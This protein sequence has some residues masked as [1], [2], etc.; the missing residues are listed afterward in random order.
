ME[1]EK[2]V[3]LKK[4][5]ELS[6]DDFN[7]YFKA[8]KILE[9]KGVIGRKKYNSLIDLRKRYELHNENS[10][11]NEHLKL[12]EIEEK[13]ILQYESENAILD[14]E[15]HLKEKE[16]L[17]NLRNNKTNKIQTIEGLSFNKKTLYYGFLD[18]YKFLYQKDFVLNSDTKPNL[19]III[20]Y[21]TQDPTFFDCE[22]LV[23][24]I[25]GL[26][27]KMEPSF[28]KGFIIVGRY[29]NGKS[30]IMKTFEFLINHNYQVALEKKWDNML[31]WQSKRFKIANTHDLVTEYEWISSP[32]EKETFIKKY[33]TFRYCFDDLKKEKIAS[34]Y[35]NI[36]VVQTLLEKRYDGLMYSLKIVDK[37]KILTFGT[38]NYESKKP[39]DLFLALKEIGD[40]YG[41]HVFDRIFEMC[42]IIEFK[43]SSFRS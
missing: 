38:M 41:G 42:N 5:L 33:R 17:S 27:K 16:Y 31:L 34:N 8:D 28:D 2:D 10:P 23:K 15:K 39:G 37:P 32:D 36:N 22:R 24:S 20:K 1:N 3:E 12:T 6:Q 19:E 35:G 26:G 40:K 4:D 14:K 18:A 7:W 25:N 11:I 9:D 43:G 29:G 13:Q 21:F 30:S